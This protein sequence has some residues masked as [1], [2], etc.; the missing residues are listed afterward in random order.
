MNRA[1]NQ[2][3]VVR[4]TEWPW[5]V[6]PGFFV[7]VVAAAAAGFGEA[8]TGQP[9]LLIALLLGLLLHSFES[10]L[11]GGLEFCAKRVL[12]IGIAFLG[13][14][15]SLGSWRAFVCRLC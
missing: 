6:G 2:I 1:I 5:F 11:N 10:R 4:W 13:F 14:R 15:V 12:E 9:S 8:K 7:C 3:G